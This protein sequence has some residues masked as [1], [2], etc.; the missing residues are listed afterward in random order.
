MDNLIFVPIQTRLFN[1]FYKLRCDANNV[2][3]SGH[4]TPPHIG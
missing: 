3:W 1:D 4:F 2:K